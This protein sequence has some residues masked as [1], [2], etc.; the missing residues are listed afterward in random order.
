MRIGVYPSPDCRI[1]R[2]FAALALS[3][4]AFFDTATFHS[5]NQRQPRNGPEDRS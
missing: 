3:P 1:I 4:P 2:P 5:N